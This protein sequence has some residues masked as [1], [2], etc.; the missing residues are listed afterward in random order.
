MIWANKNNQRVQATPKEKAICPLCNEEVISKC[1]TI[2][3]WHW[4]H[5]SD[6][7]CDSF[8]EPETEWHFNWKKKFPNESQEVRMENHR[9]D[10]R[11]KEN[12]I[13]LQN[14][15]I[16]FE[17]I[18]ERERF[19]GYKLIWILNGETLGK[20]FFPTTKQM[21]KGY[22]WNWC[23][24][25]WKQSSCRIYVDKYNFIYQIYGSPSRKGTCL[26]LSKDAF[27]IEH[28]GNPWKK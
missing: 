2:K 15:S 27:I 22:L 28:G 23:P 4:A 25:S 13:E 11:T 3:I 10:I 14:S 18:E 16:S 24:P 20:N 8:G 1:G 5:K 26:K 9:A 21:G 7:E 17:Q 12:I 6:T 19:Y